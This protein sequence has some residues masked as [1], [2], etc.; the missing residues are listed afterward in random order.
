MLTIKLS[1]PKPKVQPKPK[2]EPKPES[3]PKPKPKPNPALNPNPDPN[4][5]QARHGSPLRGGDCISPR[6][7]PSH[8]GP[9]YISC[10]R[11]HVVLACARVGCLRRRD[12]GLVALRRMHAHQQSRGR[13]IVGWRASSLDDLPQ[14]VPQ[15]QLR[16]FLHRAP[17]TH[18]LLHVWLHTLAHLCAHVPAHAPSRVLCYLSHGALATALSFRPCQAC[19]MPPRASSS[20]WRTSLCA[21]TSRAPLF[22]SWRACVRR[23]RHRV[24]PHSSSHDQAILQGP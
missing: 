8:D 1:L 14:V 5:N 16:S 21:R 9:V 10:S 15:T 4:P 7:G 11:L 2:P 17:A 13:D 19:V 23:P 6:A 24:S 18:R 22:R 20:T 3:K 12:D